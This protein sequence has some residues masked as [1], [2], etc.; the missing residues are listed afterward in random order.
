[1]RISHSFIQK[2]L[3]GLLLGGRV[4]VGDTLHREKK[5]DV[6]IRVGFASRYQHLLAM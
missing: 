4:G 2:F 1:M 5:S 6:E 3:K